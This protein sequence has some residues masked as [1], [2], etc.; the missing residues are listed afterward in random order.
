MSRG[1]LLAELAVWAE[2]LT[3]KQRAV[4]A[5]QTSL[6]AAE[7]ALRQRHR[8][9]AQF[10]Q[11]LKGWAARV[12]IKE[13]NWDSERERL[14]TEVRGREEAAEKYLETL[15]ALRRSWAKRRLQEME[16][17][18]AERAACEELREDCAILREECWKRDLSL[19]Q[20][21]RE[22]AEKTLALEEFREQLVLRSEDPAATET[23]LERLRKHWA[24]QNAVALRVSAEQFE[25]LRAE[26]SRLQQRGRDLLQIAEELTNREGQLSQRQSGWEQTLALADA[27]Q[28]KLHQQLV[29][30][31]IY[32]EQCEQQIAALQGEIERLAQLLLEGAETPMLP[33]AQ[34]A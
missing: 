22:L 16:H 12:R 29:Q 8:E 27:E 21:Q 10:K 20:Q 17:L 32:R 2:S 24:Q 4:D 3:Q 14:L 9:L 13:L 28:A 6:D 19:E 11:N 25:R 7:A 23:R 18:S 34:A 1:Q 30:G 33:P 31:E 5:R 15:G 26:A